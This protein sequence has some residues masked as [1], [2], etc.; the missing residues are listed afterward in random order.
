MEFNII[1]TVKN[2]FK[3]PAPLDE[4]RKDISEIILKD[5]YVDGLY[6]IEKY[7]FLQILYYFDCYEGY[8]LKAPRHSGEIRGFFA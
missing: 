3:E 6:K 4:I 5:E 1:A 2:S 7:D 8:N